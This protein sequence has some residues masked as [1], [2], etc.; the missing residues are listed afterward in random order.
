L[1][2]S[3]CVFLCGTGTLAGAFALAD[4]CLLIAETFA[5]AACTPQNGMS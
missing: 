5:F 1:V 4:C 2:T 3:S